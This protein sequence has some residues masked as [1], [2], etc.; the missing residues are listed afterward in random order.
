MYGKIKKKLLEK[1]IKLYPWKFEKEKKNIFRHYYEKLFF[2]WKMAT[3]PA[4]KNFLDCLFNKTNISHWTVVYISF[5]KQ[6]DRGE[7]KGE[8]KQ[9]VSFLLPPDGK[10]KRGE[11]GGWKSL[12]FAPMARHTKVSKWP[13]RVL[14]LLFLKRF[15]VYYLQNI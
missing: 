14:L 6:Q 12:L 9:S 10:R 2:F 3:E 4:N 8:E 11:W 5:K 15:L 1:R 13:A 7:K